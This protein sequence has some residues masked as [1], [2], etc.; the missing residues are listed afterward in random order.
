[1]KRREFITVLGGAAATLATPTSKAD[2]QRRSIARIGFLVSGS[3]ASHGP[4]VAA[5]LERLGALGHA[6][7]RDFTVE[8]RWAEG[9][10]ERLPPLAEE[11]AALKPDVVVTA[12]AA[13]ALAAKRAMPATPIVSATLSS[14]PVGVGLVASL[15]RPG[16][17]VTGILF[18]VE[19]LY[20]KQMQLAR[21]I[22]PATSRIGLLVNMR[23]PDGTMQRGDAE[24]QAATL[25]ITLLPVDVLSPDHLDAAFEQMVRE[26][27]DF[28]LILSDAIFVTVRQRLAAVALQTKM[29]TMFGLREFPVA[30]GLVSYGID[31]RENWRRAAY[32]VDRILRGEKPAS[33]P[34]EQ[35]T[36]FETVINLKTAKALGLDPPPMLL[37]RA[38]E[39]I[40]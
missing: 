39:V 18:T 15:N 14:D 11:L 7:G 29:P 20:G 24:A 3:P 17:N 21:E 6:Q 36:K 1:V 5:F 13:A 8:Q 31:L 37:G 34:V 32:Y 40:E 38:D 30:G 35:P 23:N 9:R 22:K 33:L 12:I 26:R 27:C 4:F 2:A 10:V 19:G 25:G 28:A 16:G